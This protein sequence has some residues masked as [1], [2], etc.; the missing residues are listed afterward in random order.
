MLTL[1]TPKMKP[2]ILGLILGRNV[3]GPESPSSDSPHH[4]QAGGGGGGAFSR[5]T[6]NG[7]ATGLHMSAGL[8]L[9]PENGVGRLGWLGGRLL[10]G[11]D[12]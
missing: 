5:T 8:G 4:L 9:N 3:A 12:F 6:Q 11:V 10:T 1:M 2:R 7:R